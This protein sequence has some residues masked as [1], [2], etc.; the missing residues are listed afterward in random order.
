MM[1]IVLRKERRSQRPPSLCENGGPEK[2]MGEISSLA[3]VAAC[4]EI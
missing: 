2:K 4:P 3:E 1:P